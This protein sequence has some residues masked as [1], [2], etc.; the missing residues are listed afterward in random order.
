[1]QIALNALFIFSFCVT[2]MLLFYWFTIK[3]L[4]EGK[5]TT[6][7]GETYRQTS[8]V[9]FWL[10]VAAGVLLGLLALGVAILILFHPVKI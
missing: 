10:S 4:K 3:S 1:M 9:S 2:G 8:P 7:S 6:R 5:V